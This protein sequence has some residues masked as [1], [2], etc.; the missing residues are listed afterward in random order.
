MN[1]SDAELLQIL[2]E[3]STQNASF[4]TLEQQMR[5]HPALAERVS[6]LLNQLESEMN[7][8][9]S[10]SMA[11]FYAKDSF[12]QFFWTPRS[13]NAPS[14]YPSSPHLPLPLAPNKK[15]KKWLI[16]VVALVGIFFLIPI[17]WIFE[18]LLQSLQLTQQ[19]IQQMTHSFQQISHGQKELAQ[20]V[21]G[22]KEQFF[23]EQASVTQEIHMVKKHPAQISHALE[24]EEDIFVTEQEP[25]QWAWH[26]LKKGQINID[27]SQV[28]PDFL[29]KNAL[30]N[31]EIDLNEGKVESEGQLVGKIAYAKG[32]VPR[33]DFSP[34]KRV[35][36]LQKK[37]SPKVPVGTFMV[38]LG[39]EQDLP[40]G[41]IVCDGREITP[42]NHQKLFNTLK[43]VQNLPN[44][45]QP[46]LLKLPDFD[47][48]VGQIF[49]RE[50]PKDINIRK[51][52]MRVMIKSDEE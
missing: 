10:E 21:K 28:S 26:S 27:F 5:L 24:W 25:T 11:S 18:L 33:E 39:K 49:Q 20:E 46:Y 16:G 40:Q 9:P 38:F 50:D 8:W 51:Y 22:L 2:Q 37:I 35:I 14:R 23:Q 44:E 17:L 13:F 6:L 12:P 45:K 48:Q 36:S 4:Q 30:L 52:A 31:L 1:Y 47:S 43:R 7:Q 42:Q 32:L 19:Q 3:E 34:I 29:K 15:G 41:W